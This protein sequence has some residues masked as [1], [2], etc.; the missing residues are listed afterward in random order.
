M[1]LYYGKD[2]EL[3]ASLDN[4]M[5]HGFC[6][7]ADGYRDFKD[8]WYMHATQPVCKP[9]PNW[10]CDISVDQV[11]GHVDEYVDVG[12]IKVVMTYIDRLETRSTKLYLFATALITAI[13]IVVLSIIKLWLNGNEKTQ[14]ISNG[15]QV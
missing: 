7:V 15:C 1:R 11:K 5:D 6:G 12:C 9:H 2:V 3:T 10:T 14:F 8:E 4:L 13:N